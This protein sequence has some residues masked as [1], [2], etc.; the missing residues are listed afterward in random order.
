MKNQ[1]TKA[2]E[3]YFNQNVN[4]MLKEAILIGVRSYQ[5][6]GNS[7]TKNILDNLITEYVQ[8]R[9]ITGLTKQKVV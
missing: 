4:L 1:I 6:T 5:K 8:F 7:Q 9:K 3:N 2:S